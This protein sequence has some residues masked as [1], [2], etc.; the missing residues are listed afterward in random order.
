MLKFSCTITV[1]SFSLW[2]IFHVGHADHRSSDWDGEQRTDFSES[3]SGARTR[4]GALFSFVLLLPFCFAI[5]SILP[6]SI[7]VQVL[8]TLAEIQERHDAVREIERRLLELQ[9][10]SLCSSQ[11]AII[12]EAC[13]DMLPRSFLL[14]ATDEWVP[15]GV[16]HLWYYPEAIVFFCRFS[17]TCQWWWRPR[18]TCWTT[19]SPR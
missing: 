8:D 3:N 16:P 13:V 11:K 10:V 4:P 6:S 5:Y 1:P 15:H 14:K 18:A 7:R 17:W 19:S 2:L 12:L 9:Q